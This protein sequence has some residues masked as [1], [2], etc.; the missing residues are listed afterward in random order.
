MRCR[1]SSTPRWTVIRFVLSLIPF[2]GVFRPQKEGFTDSTS[3]LAQNG[4]A[5]LDL[6]NTLIKPLYSRPRKCFY[7]TAPARMLATITSHDKQVE[8]KTG[9]DRKEEG[10]RW[11]KG[12]REMKE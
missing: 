7:S 9:K 10:V 11:T 5:L 3:A 2:V 6:E 4:V 8:W 1:N 12:M